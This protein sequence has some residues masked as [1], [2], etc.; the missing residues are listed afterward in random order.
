MRSVSLGLLCSCAAGGMLASVSAAAMD[1]RGSIL[2]WGEVFLPG[3]HTSNF[4]GVAASGYSS[5]SIGTRVIVSAL[6]PTAQ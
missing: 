1:E 6:M 5:G 3:Y 2:G 4:V